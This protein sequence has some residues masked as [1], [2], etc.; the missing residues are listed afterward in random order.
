MARTRRVTV[1]DVARDLDLSA[2]TVSRV[3]NNSVLVSD[4]TRKRI[5]ECADRLGYVKR[6]I[7]RQASR[8]IPTVALFLPRSGESYRQLFY[9]PASLIQSIAHEFLP[10]RVNV[11]TAVGADALRGARKF[12]GVDGCLFA[13]TRPDAE[14]AA[15]L[16]KR[17]V[18]FVAI[19]RTG[20]NLPFVSCDHDAGM[21][22][23]VARMQKTGRAVRPFYLGL[24]PVAE[25]SRLRHA[26]LGAACAVAGVP[27]GPRD[28]VE[29][30]AL[31]NIDAA[32]VRRVHRA[33]KTAIVCFNDI[34]AIV[35]LNAA[36]AAGIRV[37]ADLMVTGFDNTPVMA[38]SPMCIDTIDLEVDLLGKTA[39]EWLRAAILAREEPPIAR[40]V[41]GRYVPGRTIGGPFLTL[42]EGTL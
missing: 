16:R 1:Y 27:F 22:A 42:K 30:R 36:A 4:G 29:V 40:L 3:L 31:S 32:L 24:L 13:F 19:N 20:P 5:L 10:S 25:V 6:T 34:V 2:A 14:L 23:L 39:S 37:P 41:A 8:A 18:P 9:D 38:M 12:G 28:D 11:V 26:A 17:K 33:G 15:S 21:R 35:V 7:R